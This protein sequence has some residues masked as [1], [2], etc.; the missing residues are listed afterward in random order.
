MG[1]VAGAQ[2]ENA[3]HEE[4]IGGCDGGDVGLPEGEGGDGVPCFG[5]V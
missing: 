3:V 5:C 4:G 1:E 2:G